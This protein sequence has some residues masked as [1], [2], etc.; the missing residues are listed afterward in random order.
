MP[1]DRH[2]SLFGVLARR[3]RVFASKRAIRSNPPQVCPG[4]NEKSFLPIAARVDVDRTMLRSLKPGGSFTQSNPG[5][6]RWDSARSRGSQATLEVIA[7]D[8]SIGEPRSYQSPNRKTRRY[9]RCY[10]LVQRT[11]IIDAHVGHIGRSARRNLKHAHSRR[12]DCA[13]LV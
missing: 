9:D 6:I 4:W 5:N 11:G 10:L 1:G 2:R 8:D 12:P 7:R 3:V 13:D